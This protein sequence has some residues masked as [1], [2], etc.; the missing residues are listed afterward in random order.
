M[1]GDIIKGGSGGGD[2]SRT[3]L[4]S[5]CSTDGNLG[6]ILL[7]LDLV[8]SFLFSSFLFMLLLLLWPLELERDCFLL[9]WYR[10]FLL[11]LE[12]NLELLL[13]LLLLE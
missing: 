4:T 7:L 3:M 11:S 1:G 12:L 2:R 8:S 6:V 10:A 13:L 9:V 5:D